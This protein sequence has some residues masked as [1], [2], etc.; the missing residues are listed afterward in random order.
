MEGLK[1]VGIGSATYICAMCGGVFDK[2]ISEEDA[3]AEL[4]GLFGEVPL[5]EDL[6]WLVLNG[7]P[8]F[9]S[10]VVVLKG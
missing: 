9:H 4:H 8:G 7:A 10:D 2:E 3:V 6:D 1:V 5:D